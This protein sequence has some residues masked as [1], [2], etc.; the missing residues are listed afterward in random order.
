M[1]ARYILQNFELYNK[2]LKGTQEQLYF[3][4]T[5]ATDYV[6]EY[7]KGNSK[8]ESI[9]EKKVINGLIEFFKEKEDYRFCAQLEKILEGKPLHKFYTF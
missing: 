8:F 5:T 1:P 2:Y 4:N 3:M 7:K 6:R 9:E